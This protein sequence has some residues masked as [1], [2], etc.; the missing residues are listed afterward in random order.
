MNKDIN[1]ILA[2]VFFN[3]FLLHSSYAQTSQDFLKVIPEINETP[4]EWAVKMYEL[5]PN[6]KE[7]VQLFED[8]YKET[9]FVKTTHT[10]NFKHW[11]RN[12]EA[13]V[14]EDG[15]LAFLDPK[16]KEAIRAQ[17]MLE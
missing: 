7:V 11:I 3:V 5:N 12:I 14:G 1:L 6:V 17:L 13:Y 9:P 10:Q 8:Y 4:P 15:Y 16:E 2:F